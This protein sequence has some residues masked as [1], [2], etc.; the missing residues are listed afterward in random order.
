VNRLQH[1]EDLGGWSRDFNYDQYGNMWVTNATGIAAAG[2]TA[3]GNYETGSNRMYGFGYDLAGNQLTANGDALS[4]DA[5]N[6][7]VTATGSASRRAGP[8][9]PQCMY[10]MRWGS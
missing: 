8:A 5:E 9:A 4:Y 10:T 3:Q 7:Q 6:R 1:G 2:A